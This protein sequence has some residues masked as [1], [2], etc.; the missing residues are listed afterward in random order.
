MGDRAQR[1]GEGSAPAQRAE[2]VPQRPIQAFQP[3]EQGG[4]QDPAQ[5]GLGQQPQQHGGGV[6]VPG[7]DALDRIGLPAIPA[8]FI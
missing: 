2:G 7:D 6:G 5:P 4:G 3:V 1:L 8:L